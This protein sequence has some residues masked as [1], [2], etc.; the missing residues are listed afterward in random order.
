MQELVLDT[1]RWGYGL[2]PVWLLRISWMSWNGSER[3]LLTA[4]RQLHKVKVGYKLKS[5]YALAVYGTPAQLRAA[6]GA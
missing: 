6:L 3:R 2:L 1:F 4:R 5:M